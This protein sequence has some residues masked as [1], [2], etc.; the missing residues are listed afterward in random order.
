MKMPRYRGVSISQM[1]ELDRKTII[2]YRIPGT[3]LMENAGRIL[4]EFVA[5]ASDLLD[6]RSEIKAM[7][8]M[9]ETMVLPQYN[10]PL[11]AAA[12]KRDS[13]LQP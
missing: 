6:S 3:V 11:K 1:K 12:N 4:K 13:M 8:K 5:G 10:N 7:F 9:D 2:N